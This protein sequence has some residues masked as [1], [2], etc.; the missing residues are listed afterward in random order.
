MPH[1]ALELGAGRQNRCRRD[2]A[3]AQEV[4]QVSSLSRAAEE[5]VELALHGEEGGEERARGASRWASSS[6]TVGRVE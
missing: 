2:R 6:R 5:P 3:Q 4:A 1:A